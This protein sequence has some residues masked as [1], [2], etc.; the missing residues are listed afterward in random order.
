MPF[1]PEVLERQSCRKAWLTKS[2]TIY[3]KGGWR[4][5]GKDKDWAF[6]MKTEVRAEKHLESHDKFR[7]K[8]TRAWRSRWPGSVRH[9]R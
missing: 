1:P 8:M 6:Q 7:L 4:W 2:P 9:R 3:P 5:S